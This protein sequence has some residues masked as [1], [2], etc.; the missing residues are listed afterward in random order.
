MRHVVIAGV[1][2]L[3]LSSCVSSNAP[4]TTTTDGNGTSTSTTAVTTTS[5]TAV[6]TTSKSAVTTTSPSASTKE[7]TA[8]PYQSLVFMLHD[9]G[10]SEPAAGPFLAPVA[11]NTR[12]LE[13]TIEALLGGLTPSEIDLGITSAVPENT[14]L[15]S[16]RVDDGIATVDLTSQFSAGVGTFSMRARLAQLVYTVT[17]YDPAITG[18]RLELDG[19]PVSVFSSDGIVLDDPMTRV[20]FEDLLPGILVERPP[21]DGW[22][23]PPVTVTGIASTLQGSFRLEILD[24][25][26][27]MAVVAHEIVHT[28]TCVGWCE[29]SV[30][31]DASDL[32]P[33]S[34]YPGEMATLWIRVYELSPEDGTVTK[35][36][37][38]PFGYRM[39]P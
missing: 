20:S 5:T 24:E 32:P 33:L 39:N 11:G 9:S 18:V 29:F 16:V 31:F 35:E 2:A 27:D 12:N 34:E 26:K 17:G 22:S 10:G 23:R 15:N 36:R 6:T 4:V 3:A 13:E 30:T 25:T 14:R 1:V 21:F 19:T 7:E 37:V 28:G 8:G 38:Q